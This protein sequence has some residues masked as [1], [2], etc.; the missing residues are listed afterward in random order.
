MGT[1]DGAGPICLLWSPGGL[2]AAVLATPVSAVANVSRTA[3]RRR[4]SS[5]QRLRAEH[6]W[7]ASMEPRILPLSDRSEQ[8]CSSEGAYC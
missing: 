2:S 7:Q 1:I 4:A 8:P 6:F 5:G 3:P